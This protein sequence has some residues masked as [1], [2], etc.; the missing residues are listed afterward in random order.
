MRTLVITA[1]SHPQSGLFL[2]AGEPCARETSGP[3]DT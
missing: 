1:H 3:G 2:L